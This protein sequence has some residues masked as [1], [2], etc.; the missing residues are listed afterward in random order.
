[1]IFSILTGEVYSVN[2]DELKN[3]DEFQAVLTKKFPSSCKKC[4]GRGYVGH[5]CR[6]EDTEDYKRKTRAVKTDTLNLCMKCINKC[7]ARP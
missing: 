5:M 2:E 6:L 4:H 7:V 3:L 1:M